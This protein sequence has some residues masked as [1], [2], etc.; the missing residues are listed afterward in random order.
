MRIEKQINTNL[1]VSSDV[2]KLQLNYIHSQE[3]QLFDFSSSSLFLIA[4]V[5]IP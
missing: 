3:I 5:S 4:I 2:F 1:T